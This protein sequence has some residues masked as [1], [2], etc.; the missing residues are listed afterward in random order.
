MQ[1][2]YFVV[3]FFD[4]SIQG[5][6][7]QAVVNQS[8]E[9]LRDLLNRYAEQGWEYHRSEE[10]SLYVNPGCIASIFGQRSTVH[11]YKQLIFRRV[12][13]ARVP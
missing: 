7:N 13:A 2:E 3:A 12:A 8:C 5:Q 4:Q 11:Q 9:Q 6:F 10:V 1:H